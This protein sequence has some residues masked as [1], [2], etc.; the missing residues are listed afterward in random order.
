MGYFTPGAAAMIAGMGA[1]R[2]FELLSATKSNCQMAAR[3][4]RD[5]PL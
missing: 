2:W 3:G 4:T 1:H 5:L